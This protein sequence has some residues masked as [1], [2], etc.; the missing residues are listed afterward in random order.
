MYNL[1]QLNMNEAQAKTA[2]IHFLKKGDVI[3]I[4]LKN[5]NKFWICILK[6]IF[7]SSLS[8]MNDD[9]TYH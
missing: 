1:K 9:N 7:Q 4:G 5:E 2:D 6:M 3:A 8:C